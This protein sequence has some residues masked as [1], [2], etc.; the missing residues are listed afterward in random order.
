M[1]NPNEPSGI[2][3]VFLGRLF[4]LLLIGYALNNIIN[5]YIEDHYV[6]PLDSEAIFGTTYAQNITWQIICSLLFLAF[7]YFDQRWLKD[8]AYAAKSSFRRGVLLCFM[9]IFSLSIVLYIGVVMYSYLQG[10]S[11][12]YGLLRVGVAVA[13]LAMGALY[14]Y[15]EQADL[16]LILKKSYV[17]SS[18]LILTLFLGISLSA[19]NTYAAPSFMRQ[20]QA[21]IERAE[22]LTQVKKKIELYYQFNKK[23]PTEFSKKELG[24]ED[25]FILDDMNFTRKSD[26][27]FE[28]CANF[29]TDQNRRIKASVDFNLKKG[30]ICKIHTFQFEKH[31]GVIVKSYTKFGD[32]PAFMSGESLGADS[33]R[34]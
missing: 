19:L 34:H 4:T 24:L 31:G 23:M 3:F 14:T 18:T 25:N 10:L 1:T 22:R 13:I 16:N 9:G 8:N 20:A 29:D 11:E 27:S 12:P 17:I 7:F 26:N 32:S 21:D 5:F 30:R 15:L 33:P 6:L 28:V 2:T